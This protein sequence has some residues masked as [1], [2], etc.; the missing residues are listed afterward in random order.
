VNRKVDEMKAELKKTD[1]QIA[2]YQVRIDQ[3]PK[4]E[5]DLSVIMQGYD[6]AKETYNTLMKK[7]LDA[8]QINMLEAQNQQNYFKVLEPATVPEKPFSPKK[9]NVLLIGLLVGLGA[10]IG[11]MILMEFLD[12]S[13]HTVKDVEHYLGAEV[14]ASIADHKLAASGPEKA[15]SF[16]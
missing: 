16:S 5:Q 13:F 9:S 4:V 7:Q 12:N 11:I 1:G 10:G 8:S 6:N 3:A 15:Q 14:L 2:L